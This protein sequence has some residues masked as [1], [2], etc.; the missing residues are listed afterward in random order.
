[1]KCPKYQGTSGEGVRN[2]KLTLQYDGTGYSGWQSQREGRTVQRVLEEAVF[3]LTGVHAKIIGA[4]R[5]DAGVHALGQVA[6]FVTGSGLPA[7]TIKRALNALLPTDIRVLDAEEVSKDFHPQYSSTGKVYFYIIA[8]MGYT[9]AF[10]ERHV[11]R[12]PHVLDLGAMRRA[13]EM[14]LGTHDFRAFMGAGSEVKTTERELRDLTV[15]GMDGIGFLGAEIEGRFIRITVEGSGFL[16]HMV[17]NMV[18]TLVEVGRGKM[19]PDSIPGILASV[20]RGDAGPTAPARG[21]FL[22]KVLYGS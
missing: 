8:N 6:S 11:W 12:V 2:I 21:L 18:G 3:S 16:R 15:E 10:L 9:P 17:R 13:G 5:T 19:P 7:E 14:F 1:M 22:E 4:G 20:N